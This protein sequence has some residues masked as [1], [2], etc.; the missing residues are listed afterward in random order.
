M[1][2][3]GSTNQRHP[4]TPDASTPNGTRTPVH[5]DLAT[6]TDLLHELEA[7]HPDAEVRIAQQPA[8]PFEDAI[9]PGNAA[10]QSTGTAPAWS[11]PVRAP[12]SA[13][14][15]S[16]PA[17]AR[18]IATPSSREPTMECIPGDRV[19]LVAT[20]DPYT[21]LRA[22]DRGTVTSV[23]DSPEPTIDIQW[24]NGSTLAILPDA[25]DQI[26]LLPSHDPDP[27]PSSP[28]MPDD[29]TQPRYPE[30]QVQ[31]SG[32]DGNAFA[33]LGRTTAALRAAGVPSE[34][35]D[36]YFAE[37]TSGDYDHLLQTTMAWVDSE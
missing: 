14:S 17:P 13:T 35:I 20:N 23:S 16:L 18:L 25:G 27:P 28:A 32:Q 12:S 26:R 33:I 36:A 31:L 8:W 3:S 21:R 7:C 30:V 11:T 19:E 29:P 5:R 15:P 9:D 1:V 24:D 22:G 4:S 2:A 37:A 34:E 10:V 6:V